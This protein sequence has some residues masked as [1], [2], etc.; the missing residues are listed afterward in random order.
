MTHLDMSR[1]QVAG[2]TAF[3]HRYTQVA[4]D[5]EEIVQHIDLFAHLMVCD[6]YSHLSVQLSHSTPAINESITRLLVASMKDR[7]NSPAP[8]EI[9]VLSST[10]ETL[11]VASWTATGHPIEIVR[12]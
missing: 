1:F 10:F 6:H 4:T 3:S 2:Y 8:C 12:V 9:Y 7:K 11:D 5:P